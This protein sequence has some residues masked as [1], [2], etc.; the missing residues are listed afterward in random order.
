MNIIDKLNTL[1]QKAEEEFPDL[2]YGGCCVFASLVADR[3]AKLGVQA[4]GV[5]AMYFYEDKPP[6]IDYARNNVRHIGDGDEWEE[7]GVK[8]SHVGLKIMVGET[9]ILYDSEGVRPFKRRN[10]L[11]DRTVIEGTLSRKELKALA[12]NAWNWNYSFDRDQIPKLAKLVAR[13]LTP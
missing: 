8:L 6:N 13:E 10:T 7:N 5:V 12:N 9:A 4:E 11:L 3:L 1:G 2:N